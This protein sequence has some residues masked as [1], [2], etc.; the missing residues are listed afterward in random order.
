MQTTL[1]TNVNPDLSAAS[2]SAIL[3]LTSDLS[4]WDTR[5]TNLKTVKDIV[6]VAQTGLTSI[7]SLMYQMKTLANL[8][9]SLDPTSSTYDTE[10]NS[11]WASYIT[12]ANQIT[13]TASSAYINSNSNNLLT[14]DDGITIYPALSSDTNST[15]ALTNNYEDI[16][17]LFSDYSWTEGDTDYLSPGVTY[18]EL[19][20]YISKLSADQSALTGYGTLL[21]S[22]IS[23]ITGIESGINSY[24]SNLQDI[25]TTALQADLQS[26]NNQLS[27]DYYLVGQMNAAASSELAIFH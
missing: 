15:I 19:T 10:L 12:L 6:D 22:A 20:T 17:N 23:N 13:N 14:S 21:S 7:S 25:D 1:A 3:T 4:T 5:A 24:I 2:A 16:G 27:I 18:D 9:D 8:A 11:L 26:Y